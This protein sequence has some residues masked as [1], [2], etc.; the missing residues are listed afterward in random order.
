MSDNVNHPGHYNQ[1]GMEVIDVL[2]AFMNDHQIRGF[3][4]GNVIKYT[5]RARYKGGKEDLEKAR[6][7]LSYYLDEV[8]N[9]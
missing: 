8:E 5:L 7:Y 9:D 2:R 6:W 1:N 4:L 3:C